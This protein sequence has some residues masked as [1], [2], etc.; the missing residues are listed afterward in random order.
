MICNGGR[1][2]N[3]LFCDGFFDSTSLLNKSVAEMTF[4]LA[5]I[6]N[7]AFVAPYHDAAGKTPPPRVRELS[8]VTEI[9]AGCVLLL[10]REPHLTLFSVPTN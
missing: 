5:K 8:V 7:V 6:L 2:I 9:G 3:V 1:L 10:Q 4:S